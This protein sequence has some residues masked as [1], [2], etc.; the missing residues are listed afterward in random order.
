VAS[1]RANSKV[2]RSERTPHLRPDIRLQPIHSAGA[3]TLHTLTIN[4]EESI[5]DPLG[6]GLRRRPLKNLPAVLILWY[7][8]VGAAGT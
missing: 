8:A 5:Y 1:R 3:G 4:W 2:A 7:H 6:P